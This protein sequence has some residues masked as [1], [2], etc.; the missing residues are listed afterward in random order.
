MSKE[1]ENA[2]T[3]CFFFFFIIIIEIVNPQKMGVRV[4]KGGSANVSCGS[5]ALVSRRFLVLT[6][7]QTSGALPW[8]KITRS[9]P[10]EFKKLL[11]VWLEIWLW[12]SRLTRRVG[13]E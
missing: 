2:Q 1:R 13:W 6:Y 7:T 4:S 5:Q 11:G 8:D 3:A 10:V 9:F 12:H